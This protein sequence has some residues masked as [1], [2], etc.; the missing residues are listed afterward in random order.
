[1]PQKA[2]ISLNKLEN[3]K[4]REKCPDCNSKDIEYE[5]GERFCK[6]CDYVFD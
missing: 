5:K 3:E 2:P 4:D 1:M 6:K